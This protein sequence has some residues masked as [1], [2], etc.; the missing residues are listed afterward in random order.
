MY[1]VHHMAPTQTHGGDELY[2]NKLLI[3]NHLLLFSI[4]VDRHGFDRK[5]MQQATWQALFSERE[6]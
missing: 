3:N 5:T 2:G 6:F 4:G 1:Q